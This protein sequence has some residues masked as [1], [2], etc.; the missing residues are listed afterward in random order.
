MSI[1]A[2]EALVLWI[3]KSLDRERLALAMNTAQVR[4]SKKSQRAISYPISIFLSRYKENI[5]S[6]FFVL[7]SLRIVKNLTFPSTIWLSLTLGIKMLIFE[8]G[9]FV[10]GQM[11]QMGFFSIGSVCWAFIQH[12]TP[13]SFQELHMHNFLPLSFFSFLYL[14]SNLTSSYY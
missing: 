7:P 13:V 3:N 10:W 6:L 1:N 12:Y 11:W 14:S 8:K 9:I 4:K 2:S 5:Q